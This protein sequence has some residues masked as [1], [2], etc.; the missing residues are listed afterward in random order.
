MKV[1]EQIAP[2]FATG[3]HPAADREPGIDVRDR[4]LI[5]YYRQLVI[6][7]R[8]SSIETRTQIVGV[9]S[10]GAGEGVSTVAISLAAAAASMLD[11][12][13]LLVEQAVIGSLAHWLGLSTSRGIRDYLDGT[14]DLSD[15]LA[16]TAI[17]RLSLLPAGAP[18]GGMARPRDTATFPMLLD[19][20]RPRFGLIVV[21][22]PPVDAVD[23]CLPSVGSLDGVL[24][25]IAAERVSG[26][27]AHRA[28]NRLRL[29]GANLLGAVLNARTEHT[30]DWLT[31]HL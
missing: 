29:A 20:L 25:L 24:L 17:E 9:T 8:Q 10:S 22:L 26:A 2:V 16:A 12:Q 30:P 5:G 13:V 4:T 7:L 14:A 23:G 31:R 27:A 15:C 18:P 11:E 1:L 6:G 28:A 21:D 19:A 3:A